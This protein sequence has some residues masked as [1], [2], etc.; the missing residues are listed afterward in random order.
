MTKKQEKHQLPF[1]GGVASKGMPRITEIV[2]GDELAGGDVVFIMWYT[3]SRCFIITEVQ[4]Y[5]NIHHLTN[6]ST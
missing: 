2:M 4:K 6:R 5:W 3:K 1:I